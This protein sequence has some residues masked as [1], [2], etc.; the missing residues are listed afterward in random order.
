MKEFLKFE[1]LLL[2]MILVGMSWAADSTYSREVV[3]YKILIPNSFAFTCTGDNLFDG[4]GT[5]GYIMTPYVS[6]SNNGF[7]L[8]PKTNNV[9]GYTLTANAGC[10]TDPDPVIEVPI[11]PYPTLTV[12]VPPPRVLRTQT[13]TI[14]VQLANC[15]TNGWTCNVIYTM[16]NNP[17]PFILG[18]NVT[19]NIQIPANYLDAGGY[20]YVAIM[21]ITNAYYGQMSNQPFSFSA[22]DPVTQVNVTGN[23]TCFENIMTIPMDYKLTYSGACGTLVDPNVVGTTSPTCSSDQTNYKLILNFAA[24]GATT[25]FSMVTARFN[26]DLV[27]NDIVNCAKFPSTS[28]SVS[29]PVLISSA[30]QSLSLSCSNCDTSQP[31][32]IAWSRVSGPAISFTPN[33]ETSY[34]FAGADLSVGEYTVR[35]TRRSSVSGSYTCTAEASFIRGYTLNNVVQT[36]NKF[37]F[38]A[39]STFNLGTTNCASLVSVDP[40]CA[41]AL[42]SALCQHTGGTDTLTIYAGFTHTLTA[43]SCMTLNQNYLSSSYTVTRALPG[44][45]SIT[46]APETSTQDIDMTVANTMAAALSNSAGL[47]LSY[48][49]TQVSGPTLAKNTTEISQTWDANTLVMNEY[50]FRVVISIADSNNWAFTV[51]RI[52]QAV[53][54]MISFQD[55]GNKLHMVFSYDYTFVSCA[56]VLTPA[57][58]LLLGSSP[59][60]EK[61]AAAEFDV[62]FSNDST[63]VTE[64]IIEVQIPYYEIAHPLVHPPTQLTIE[65]GGTYSTVGDLTLTG[66][67]TDD[68]ETT[69]PPVY[70]FTQTSGPQPLPNLNSSEAVQF[71]PE[72]SIISG[73]YTFH[74][75]MQFP[76]AYRDYFKEADGE[77]I[78]ST[79][80]GALR[81]A[82]SVLNVVMSW[83]FQ[84]NGALE[85]AP[86]D[87][88]EIIA[89][90][91]LTIV[92]SGAPPLCEHRGNKYIIYLTNSSEMTSG[93]VINLVDHPDFLASP[94]TFTVHNDLP[95]VT[96]SGE[97]TYDELE[98]IVL[99]GVPLNILDTFPIYTWTQLSGPGML[100]F[101]ANELIQTFVPPN[102][103][104]GEY[105]I[106]LKMGFP[107]S[108][109]FELNA[110]FTLNI[111][112]KLI[113]PATQYINKFEFVFNWRFV[114]SDSLVNEPLACSEIF[115][116]FYENQVNPIECTH[117]YDKL[118]FYVSGMADLTVGSVI[119]LKALSFFSGSINC[120]VSS[121]L[122][123]VSIAGAGMR[124]QKSTVT[125]TATPTGVSGFF[126]IYFWAQLSGPEVIPLNETDTSQ[127]VPPELFSAGDYYFKVQMEMPGFTKGYATVGTSLLVIKAKLFG[128][129]D[130]YGNKFKWPLTF[131]L[132]L[133]GNKQN[134]PVD[135]DK[136]L[137]ATTLTLLNPTKCDH[138]Y[139]LLTIYANNDSTVQGGDT[140]TSKTQGYLR[141]IAFSVPRDLPK[142]ENITPTPEFPWDS[143]ATGNTLTVNNLNGDGVILDYIW[144][145]VVGNPIASFAETNTSAIEFVPGELAGGEYEIRVGMEV[146]G[147]NGYIVHDSITF[148][149][150]IS[151]TIHFQVANLI[152]V[153]TNGPY[154]IE[155]ALINNPAC[156]SILDAASILKLGSTP[157]C[158]HD[159]YILDIFLS[160]DSS[161]GVDDTLVLVHDF[162]SGSPVTIA[163]IQ[164]V[165][166]LTLVLE[167][168]PDNFH[169]LRSEL[170]QIQGTLTRSEGIE[171]TMT[172]T[173]IGTP[174]SKI[175][176]D[177]NE[178][179]Q[180]VTEKALKAGNFSVALNVLYPNSN[181]Y[182]LNQVLPFQVASLP[183]VSIKGGKLTLNYNQQLSLN[184]SCIDNDNTGDNSQLVWEWRISL[185]NDF[186]VSI[187]LVDGS[188]FNP[189]TYANKNI[190]LPNR[191][192]PEGHYYVELKAS[193]WE[194]YSSTVTSYFDVFAE[195]PTIQLQSSNTKLKHNPLEDLCVTASAFSYDGFEIVIT[196]PRVI[197]NV[198]GKIKT[199][200]KLCLPAKE[201]QPGTNYTI[202]CMATEIPTRERRALA[203]YVREVPLSIVV[204]KFPRAGEMAVTPLSGKGFTDEFTIT[205]TNWFDVDSGGDLYYIIQTE[206]VGSITGYVS[207]NTYTT[208]STIKTFLPPGDPVYNYL[209]SVRVK[210]KNQYG[211]EIYKDVYVKVYE[212]G[213]IEDKMGYL[214]GSLLNQMENKTL[215]E[216]LFRLSTATYFSTVPDKVDTTKKIDACGGCGEN[217]ACVVSLGKCKCNTGYDGVY[218]ENTLEEIAEMT[219]VNVLILTS[220]Y[221]Y[222]YNYVLFR[223]RD[224]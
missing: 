203:L 155:N 49:W 136:I 74:L 174:P 211:A 108:N 68:V 90:D 39:D 62:Y 194:Y 93:T 83:Q 204:S 65:G 86:V 50:K 116:P 210:A 178:L 37:V 150:K 212:P 102:I 186:S 182:N 88:A 205:V 20:S 33:T 200:S 131:P 145:V 6:G 58:V 113:S 57:T 67:P 52:F 222:I 199:P 183:T 70:V 223:Y 21:T 118:T 4:K 35:A 11:L 101:T 165:P 47:T 185:E 104:A 24:D 170:T 156:S 111:L 134:T 72:G 76:P 169:Q 95:S 1:G 142:I 179:L 217:G 215:S 75:T 27:G 209:I 162:F 164:P 189:A 5:D 8:T 163:A 197:P 126:P 44:P 201:L 107:D 22:L 127:N 41:T 73:T 137:D 152:T 78:L 2:V 148:Q 180:M 207:L 91:S 97:A 206:V 168:S 15:G 25:A 48:V 216:R 12:I 29:R 171:T 160:N 28:I 34:T 63:A 151:K 10:W 45:A 81:Q 147:G 109:G 36:G 3:D 213:G 100:V 181:D 77:L 19:G 133:D 224:N 208:V 98:D 46:L 80:F 130:Q 79:T 149:L 175:Y 13:I 187:T 220:I 188:T 176:F 64:S 54:T 141:P 32:I 120:T 94:E 191:V 195:G 31:Q 132:W 66:T 139:D 17:T 117:N 92:N 218:C 16:G 135:C 18:N 221:I 53:A 140:L 161:M 122:P 119:H 55:I 192:L 146:V 112:T 219:K 157:L 26:P 153:H 172:W 23:P 173:Q 7:R 190:M 129:G 121:G 42:G 154:Y 114:L 105:K 115:D 198:L 177:N 96:I 71:I 43:G 128:D 89:A 103:T 9:G 85:N 106:Q 99:T 123:Q 214:E 144:E 60:C 61:P 159:N 166:A 167:S 51:D 125:L 40:D 30:T 143:E 87:C 196:W 158:S 82:G 56:Q 84:L 124:D 138:I 184:A 202:I 59:F 38:T 14:Q 69:P 193:K 110:N